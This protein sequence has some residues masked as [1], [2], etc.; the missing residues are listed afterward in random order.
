MPYGR[1]M[2]WIPT[3]LA[4]GAHMPEYKTDGAAALDLHALL[5]TARVLWPLV[6]TRIPTGVTLAIPPGHAGFVMGRS[7]LALGG[8]CVLG[9]VIDSD[10]RGEISAIVVLLRLWPMVLHPEDRIAQL[11][12]MPVEH[13]RLAC[14][15]SME[16]TRRGARGLGSTG[17]RP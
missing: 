15:L 9:G 6:P 10:F 4:P 12:V 8:V 13:A 16:P 17:V 14:G 2:L 1:T 7:G 5:P 3:R 11:V